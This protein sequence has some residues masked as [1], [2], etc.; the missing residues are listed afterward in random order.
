LPFGFPLPDL[1]HDASG[2]FLSARALIARLLEGKHANDA[3]AQP[4]LVN[5]NHD[6]ISRPG[7]LAGKLH[8]PIAG[9]NADNRATFSSGSF[10][11]NNGI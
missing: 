1:Q 10:I 9:E 6:L 3:R 4:A 5:K 8:R 11:G 7:R 2:P